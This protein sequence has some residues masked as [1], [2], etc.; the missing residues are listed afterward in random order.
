MEERTPATG[1][2]LGK[3]E[4]LTTSHKSPATSFLQV[5]EIIRSIHFHLL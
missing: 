5:C 3:G 2:A 1:K 4:G